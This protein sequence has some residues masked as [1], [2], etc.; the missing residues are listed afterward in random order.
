MSKYREEEIPCRGQDAN[1]ECQNSVR[2]LGAESWVLLCPKVQVSK[3]VLERYVLHYPLRNIGLKSDYISTVMLSYG[4]HALEIPYKW[5]PFPP[6]HIFR[7]KLYIYI[8]IYKHTHIYMT[9]MLIY[10][11]Y[12][13]WGI[14]IYINIYDIDIDKKIF[15]QL[16]ACILTLFMVSVTD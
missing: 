14:Y 12:I 1:L 3:Q 2:V 13:M 11:I 10:I 6:F 7:D 8:Y 5:S 16:V 15:S 9:Y 4:W